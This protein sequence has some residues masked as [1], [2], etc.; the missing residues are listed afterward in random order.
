MKAIMSPKL[1]KEIMFKQYYPK[2]KKINLRKN[3]KIYKN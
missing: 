2:K 1:E 3:K